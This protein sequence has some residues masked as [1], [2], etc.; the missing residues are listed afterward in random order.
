MAET[1]MN[2]SK[3][4]GNSSASGTKPKTSKKRMKKQ[5]RRT[6]GG[7]FLA[8]AIAVAAI[9]VEPTQAVNTVSDIDDASVKIDHTTDADTGVNT[10]FVRAVHYKSADN[11][12]FEKVPGASRS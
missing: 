5:V 10:H 12:S 2:T 11:A 4:T 7:L 1:T 3:N 6:L 8:S 9:P